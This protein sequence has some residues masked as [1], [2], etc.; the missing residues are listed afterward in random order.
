MNLPGYDEW[1]TTPPDDPDIV[2]CIK[3][4]KEIY[5]YDELE[6][7]RGY[8]CEECLELEEEEVYG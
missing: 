1:K 2:E 4:G 6:T 5:K 7:S 8:M 3:C